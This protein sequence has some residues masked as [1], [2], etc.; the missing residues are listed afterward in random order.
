MSAM[1]GLWRL[2]ALCLLWSAV[3]FAQRHSSM[4]YPPDETHTGPAWFVDVAQRAGLT[5][6]N[7]NGDTATK[8]YILE[9]TGSGVAILDYDHDGWPDIFLVNGDAFDFEPGHAVPH[10]SHL[11]HNN[12]DG[13]FTDVTQAAGLAVTGLGPGRLR[14]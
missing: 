4:P 12:H 14:R 9:T 3:A 1:L 5:M 8:K 6:Q 13:T 11:Y 7:V 10:T 2:A